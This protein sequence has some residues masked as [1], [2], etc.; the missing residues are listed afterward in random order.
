MRLNGDSSLGV[1]VDNTQESSQSSPNPERLTS[2]EKQE[3]IRRN[4]MINNPEALR[5]MLIKTGYQ[6]NHP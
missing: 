1:I 6:S 5:D 4:S 3:I 2:A